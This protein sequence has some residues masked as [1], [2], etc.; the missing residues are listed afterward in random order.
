MFV[1]LSLLLLL[2]PPTE[3]PPPLLAEAA[4]AAAEEAGVPMGAVVCMSAKPVKPCMPAVV[5]MDTVTCLTGIKR[6]GCVKGV[7]GTEAG[8]ASGVIPCC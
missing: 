5:R 3:P 7:A 1:L 8:E 2:L 6:A 4:A